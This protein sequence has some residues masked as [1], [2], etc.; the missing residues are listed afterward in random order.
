MNK[1]LEP[2]I[3]WLCTQTS[4]LLSSERSTTRKERVND[5]TGSGARVPRKRRER[6]KL[7]GFHFLI[8]LTCASCFRTCNTRLVN[9]YSLQYHK[10]SI[11]Y[12]YINDCTTDTSGASFILVSGRPLGVACTWGTRDWRMSLLP[13]RSKYQTTFC[14]RWVC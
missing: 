5:T 4:L 8:C 11:L 12:Q 9:I 7:E 6:L 1:N 10:T 14:L 13:G 2:T 3:V